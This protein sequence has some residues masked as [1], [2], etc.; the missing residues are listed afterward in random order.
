[1]RTIPSEYPYNY[2][3]FLDRLYAARRYG[4]DIVVFPEY[5]LTGF[6]EWDFSGKHYYEEI[7]S[8]ARFMA[9][10]LR[11]WIIMGVLEPCDDTAYNSAVVID[12][13]GRIILRHRKVEEPMR[14][15]RGQ[16]FS[17]ADTRYGRLGVLI[18][19]DLYNDEIVE[20]ASRKN[21]RIVFVPMDYQ[22]ETVDY[23]EERSVLAG[24][25]RML[26]SYLVVVNTYMHHGSFGSGWVFSPSGELLGFSYADNP[27]LVW[28]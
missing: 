28:V 19:G 11:I 3:M 25:A 17:F 14:F 4:A 1:M 20:E 7:V 6:T 15:C 21:P 22:P 26:G 12:D 13:S 5:C 27:L 9:Y 18:C 2:R 8:V 24:R 16:G 23:S 10:M